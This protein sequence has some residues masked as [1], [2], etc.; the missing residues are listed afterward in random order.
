LLSTAL[1][2]SILGA[3][4]CSTAP[5]NDTEPNV[6]F[7]GTDNSNEPLI[8]NA[9]IDP[10]SGHS[11]HYSALI[12]SR[13][14]RDRIRWEYIREETPLFVDD[15]NR[16]DLDTDCLVFFGMFLPKRKDIDGH[17]SS[18]DHGTLVSEYRITGTADSRD[19]R[20]KT[21]VEIVRSDDIPD[22]VTFEVRY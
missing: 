22:D 8:G 20:L 9:D 11:H 16:A 19:P 2:A 15:L 6:V 5:L 10:S 1:S 18:M 4:G 7:S 14:D 17:G 13:G 21:H 3:A 12:A